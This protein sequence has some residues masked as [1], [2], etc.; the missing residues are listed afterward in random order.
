[1]LTSVYIINRLPSSVLNNKCPYEVLYSKSPIYEDLKAFGCLDFVAASLSSTDKFAIRGVP[2]VFV[3]YPPT[4]KG[5]RLFN[6]ADKSV[7]ISRDVS[8]EETIFPFNDI[9]GSKYLHPLPI[10][11]PT[12]STSSKGDLDIFETL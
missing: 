6:L 1:M 11:M 2:C 8:F 7:L 10:Q 4:T 12:A 3:G 9:P 5:Y